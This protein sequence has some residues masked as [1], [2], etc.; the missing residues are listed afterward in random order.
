MFPNVDTVMI[1]MI[2]H[3]GC[4]HFKLISELYQWFNATHMDSKLRSGLLMVNT[5]IPGHTY[6][7]IR[8]NVL[9]NFH[10]LHYFSLFAQLQWGNT[11]LRY[12][13]NH[14]SDFVRTWYSKNLICIK[15]ITD[16]YFEYYVSTYFVIALTI[17]IWM[18][19]S[20]LNYSKCI[21]H[22]MQVTIYLSEWISLKIFKA[23]WGS[24]KKIM[25]L[26]VTWN[27]RWRWQTME[28]LMGKFPQTTT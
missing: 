5:G 25:P 2:S 12:G 20:S 13:I 7:Q 1:E 22:G 19:L 14:I 4:F 16:Y 15:K 8:Q 17:K 26:S 28:I 11:I 18:I 21:M 24:C 6:S 23:S 9:T 3:T 10:Q 27:D